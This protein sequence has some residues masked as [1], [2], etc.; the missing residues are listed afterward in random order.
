MAIKR[1]NIEIPTKLYEILKNH[2][3]YGQLRLVYLRLT[4]DLS[5]LLESHGQYAIAAILSDQLGIGFNITDGKLSYE[6]KR[7]KPRKNIKD[8][9][10]RGGGNDKGPKKAKEDNVRACILKEKR[11]KG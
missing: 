8:V 9:P 1:L 11:L 6:P 5:D 4:Q 10:P 3:E 7:P 2:L